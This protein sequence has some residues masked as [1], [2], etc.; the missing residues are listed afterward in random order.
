MRSIDQSSRR[1]GPVLRL[2]Q[3]GLAALAHPR[4]RGLHIDGQ[5]Q[6]S[7]RRQ[8]T[9][10]DSMTEEIDFLWHADRDQR[11]AWAL[12]AVFEW[13][14][15]ASAGRDETQSADRGGRLRPQ[16]GIEGDTDA[17]AASAT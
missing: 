13:W 5:G 9:R 8:W 4:R 15:D 11:A 3:Q 6:V 16:L 14:W 7:A 2:D 10:R 12:R 17:L 1:L